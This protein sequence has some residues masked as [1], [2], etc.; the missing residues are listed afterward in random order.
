MTVA[1]YVSE[2]AAQKIFNP[3]NPGDFFVPE[4]ANSTA[5]EMKLTVRP[6]SHVGR[7]AASARQ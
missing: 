7:R 5:I 4:Q 6:I 1:A 3:N 2:F